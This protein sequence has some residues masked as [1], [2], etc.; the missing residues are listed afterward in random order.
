MHC[1]PS[2]FRRLKRALEYEGDIHIRRMLKYWRYIY[3]WSRLRKETRKV[4]KAFASWDYGFLMTKVL[5]ELASINDCK[6]LDN[7]HYNF[8]KLM[9]ISEVILNIYMPREQFGMT[10]S[11]IAPFRF[12]F[13]RI[14]REIDAWIPPETKKFYNEETSNYYSRIIES[15]DHCGKDPRKHCTCGSL[16]SSEELSSQLHIIG[17]STLEGSVSLASIFMAAGVF[18]ISDLK[19]FSQEDVSRTLDKAKLNPVQFKKLFEF[20]NSRD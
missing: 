18:T 12:E 6:S 5:S 15:C 11:E 3:Q 20:L 7:E 8:F 9:E 13:K 14:L 16:P 4:L 10:A 1:N 2:F 17:I 19:G